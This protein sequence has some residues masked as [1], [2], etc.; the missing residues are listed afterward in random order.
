[1]NAS[2]KFAI[3]LKQFRVR[4]QLTVQELCHDL[5]ISESTYR[6]Y[7]YGV[8]LPANLV[9][10]ICKRYQI[11]PNQFFE[12]DEQRP[13]KNIDYL[14]R[15]LNEALSIVAKECEKSEKSEKSKD[16]ESTVNL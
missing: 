4:H 10:K 1:M 8:R 16:E 3:K 2:V 12:I 6:G 15:L 5:G 13:E 14:F 7:E 9:P 11:T